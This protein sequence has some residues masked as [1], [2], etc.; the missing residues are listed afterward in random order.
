MG[1]AFREI[2]KE[3]AGADQGVLQNNWKLAENPTL[4]PILSRCLILF[5]CCFL[6][7]KNFKELWESQG[8][9]RL[10]NIRGRGGKLDPVRQHARACGHE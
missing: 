1:I 6:H 10:V 9:G 8:A 5:L 3:M 7:E 4:T 2:L